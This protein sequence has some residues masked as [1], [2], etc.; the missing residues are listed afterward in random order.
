MECLGRSLLLLT[1]HDWAFVECLGGAF[2]CILMYVFRA[3]LIIPSEAAVAVGG[4][5]RRGGSIWTW[6]LLM[7]IIIW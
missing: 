3:V 7:G 5:T 6:N 4:H 1:L 2:F